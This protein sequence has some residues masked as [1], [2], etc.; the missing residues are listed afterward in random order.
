MRLLA[1]ALRVLLALVFVGSAAQKLTGALDLERAHL[2][3]EPWFW[4]AAALVELVGVLGLVASLGFPRLA[5]P[6]GFW[7]PGLVVGAVFARLGAGD[8]P[9]DMVVEAVLLSSAVAVALLG[10]RSWKRAK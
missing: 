4:T 2:G 5:T 10:R 8:A 6:V 9:R 1:V 7:I 3:I